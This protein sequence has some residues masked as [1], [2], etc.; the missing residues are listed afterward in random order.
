MLTET[1]PGDARL[2][3]PVKR[4]GILYHPGREKARNL[5]DKLEALLSA[6]GV[7]TWQFSTSDED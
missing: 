1:K 3:L 6:R 7:S 2:A 5:A 4:V